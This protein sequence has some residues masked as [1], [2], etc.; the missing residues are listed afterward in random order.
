MAQELT[1]ERLKEVL[2]YDPETGIFTWLKSRRCPVKSGGV[3]GTTNAKGYR[4]IMVDYRM[5]LAHRIA[6]LYIYGEMPDGMLDHHDQD[7]SNNRILNLRPAT[8]GQNMLNVGVRAD[9]TSGH[10]GVSWFKERQKWV[11]TITVDKRLHH[12]G[13]FDNLEDAVA[14]RKAGEITLG[15]SEFCPQ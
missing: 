4:Q 14:A 1:Q 9:N 2:H 10:V 15:V 3:A 11:A 8:R 5:Y 7:K 6:Y 13:Y 12:L